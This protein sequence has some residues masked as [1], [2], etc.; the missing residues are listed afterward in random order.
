MDSRR[1]LSRWKALPLGL[2]V[3]VGGLGV[4]YVAADSSTYGMG[5]YGSCSYNSCG[6][7]ITSSGSVSLNITPAASTTCTV[8]SDSVSVTTDSSSGYTLQLADG[9][10][11]NQLS[12]AAHG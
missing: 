2:L 3:L 1:S 9:D 5:T 6:V 4:P 10:T 11:S 8:G 7:S 12:G